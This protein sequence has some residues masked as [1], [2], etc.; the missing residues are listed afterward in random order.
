[1]YGNY[2]EN[3]SNGIFGGVQIHGGQFNIIDNNVFINCKIGVSWSAWG[4]RR[5]RQFLEEP[6]IKGL[7]AAVDI[8]GDLYRQRYPDLPVAPEL[9]DSNS[10]WRNLFMSCGQV[11]F[12]TPKNTDACANQVIVGKPDYDE[13]AKQST[14]RTLPPSTEM[15]PYKNAF[16]IT[17]EKIK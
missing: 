10:V 6:R 9:A 14:F 11:Y 16:R 3:T 17:N 8:D 15:G 1:V 12:R 4:E 2:F 13:I 7:M 5:F